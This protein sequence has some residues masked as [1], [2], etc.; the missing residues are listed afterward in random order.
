MIENLICDKLYICTRTVHKMM[1]RVK[2]Q[3]Q[4]KNLV[5]NTCEQV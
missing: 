1:K 4:K 5:N 3:K 2:K